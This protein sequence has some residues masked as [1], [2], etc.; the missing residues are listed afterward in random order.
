MKHQ[1]HSTDTDPDVDESPR[2][3]CEDGVGPSGE[4]GVG[5]QTRDITVWFRERRG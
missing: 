5:L 3:A 4:R 2:N 1:A